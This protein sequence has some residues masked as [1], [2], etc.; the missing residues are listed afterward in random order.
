MLYWNHINWNGKRLLLTV[1]IGQQTKT[2]KKPERNWSVDSERPERNRHTKPRWF[3][4][5]LID[6]HRKMPSSNKRVEPSVEKTER[7]RRRVRFFAPPVPST[8]PNFPKWV[9]LVVFLHRKRRRG[10]VCHAVVSAAKIRIVTVR[11][12]CCFERLFTLHNVGLPPPPGGHSAAG[13][14]RAFSE[15]QRSVDFQ[16]RAAAGFTA[17]DYDFII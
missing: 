17:V 10:S 11:C 16:P 13:R 14:P 3:W 9:R 5:R 7:A 4:A 2:R 12:V 15:V 1:I 8:L 6:A